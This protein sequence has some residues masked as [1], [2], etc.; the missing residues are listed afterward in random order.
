MSVLDNL[1]GLNELKPQIDNAFIKNSGRT[2][3]MQMLCDKVSAYEKISIMQIRK[4][5]V[6]A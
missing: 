2:T 1:A 4:P 3:P 5:K 6:D